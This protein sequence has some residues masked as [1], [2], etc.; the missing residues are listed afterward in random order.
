MDPARLIKKLWFKNYLFAGD[1]LN[2][3]NQGLMECEKINEAFG[4]YVDPRIRDEILSGRVSLDGER[5]EVAILFA[6]LRNFTPLVAVT[7]AKGLIY[8]LNSYFDEVSREK[9]RLSRCMA[10]PMSSRE[11]PFD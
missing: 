5:K 9:V 2:A 4:R 10:L 11:N 3:M 1:T 7:P 6:D 8:M